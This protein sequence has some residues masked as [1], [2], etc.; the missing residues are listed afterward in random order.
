MNKT[1][2]DDLTISLKI[3]KASGLNEAH[4]KFCEFQPEAGIH[5]DSYDYLIIV[6]LW[7]SDSCKKASEFQ[8]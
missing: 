3:H 5:K 1:S 8:L 7:L 2:Y 4:K 6:A